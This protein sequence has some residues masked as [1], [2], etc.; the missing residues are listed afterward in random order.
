MYIA[1][2]SLYR[3]IYKL[4]E[5]SEVHVERKIFQPKSTFMLFSSEYWINCIERFYV[6]GDIDDIPLPASMRPDG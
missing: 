2:S 1:K 4:L 6:A 5:N 3:S